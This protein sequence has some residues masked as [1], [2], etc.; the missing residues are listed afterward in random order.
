MMDELTTEIDDLSET[1][2]YIFDYATNYTMYVYI[3]YF[4][5]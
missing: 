4:I 3:S 1:F 2:T 5:F